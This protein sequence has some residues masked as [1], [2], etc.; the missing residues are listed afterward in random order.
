M[1]CVVQYDTAHNDFCSYS[2]PRKITMNKPTAHYCTITCMVESG[3]F[4]DGLKFVQRM[5]NVLVGNVLG[6]FVHQN[7]KRLLRSTRYGNLQHTFVSPRIITLLNIPNPGVQLKQY[8]L[9]ARPYCTLE[10]LKKST[11]LAVRA[12]SFPRTVSRMM[13]R[14]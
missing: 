11:T 5:A 10:Y 9:C 13:Q 4:D 12:V 6:D 8:I 3:N 2:I 7:G 14:K 1:L